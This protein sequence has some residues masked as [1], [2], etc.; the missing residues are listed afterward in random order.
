ML[1]LFVVFN[2]YS[3]I[4]SFVTYMVVVIPRIFRSA[5]CQIPATNLRQIK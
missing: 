2:R 1:S 5:R 3:S 4:I